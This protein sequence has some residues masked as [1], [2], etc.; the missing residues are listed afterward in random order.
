MRRAIFSD[1]QDSYRESFRRFLCEL[2]QA[3]DQHP[4][5]KVSQVFKNR[6]MEHVF[7]VLE[8]ESASMRR[9]PALQFAVKYNGY[10]KFAALLGYLTD[11]GGGAGHGKFHRSSVSMES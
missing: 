2:P 1:E 8:L 9:S 6:Y 5:R 3:A 4:L 11:G 7:A 10:A